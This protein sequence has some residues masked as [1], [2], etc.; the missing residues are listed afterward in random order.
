M[1]NVCVS[2]CFFCLFAER[3][4][5][6]SYHGL[7]MENETIVEI[8]PLIKVD[9]SKVSG[10]TIIKKGNHE[11]PFQAS[12]VFLLFV[13]SHANL[14]LRTGHEKKES[15]CDKWKICGVRKKK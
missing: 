6:S 2:I 1:D 8:T 15:M 12:I 7:I 11:V 14:E 4:L 9:G 13:L 5:E 10:F 3:I